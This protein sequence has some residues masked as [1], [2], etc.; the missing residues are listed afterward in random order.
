MR[1][2][3][4]VGIMRH[5]GSYDMRKMVDRQRRRLLWVVAQAVQKAK[6]ERG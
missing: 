3:D 1:K 6:K 5:M 2:R 4:I